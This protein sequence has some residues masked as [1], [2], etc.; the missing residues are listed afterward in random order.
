M[1][2]KITRPHIPASTQSLDK[3]IISES[4]S[5]PEIPN[6]GAVDDNVRSEVFGL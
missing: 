4:E 2:N 1:F 6:E 3:D 5:S